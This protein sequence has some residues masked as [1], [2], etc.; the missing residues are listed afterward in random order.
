MF[1]KTC[2]ICGE[3]FK[4]RRSY[5]LSCSPKCR[6]EREKDLRRQ[7]HADAPEASHTFKDPGEPIGGQDYRA[8]IY[9]SPE[10]MLAASFAKIGR[11]YGG[12]LPTDFMPPTGEM[13]A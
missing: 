11:D 13:V 1:D 2:A 9:G 5:A 7:R 3:P 8:R 10:Q 6:R 4:A 12:P